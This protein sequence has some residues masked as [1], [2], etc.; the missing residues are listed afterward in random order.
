MNV[1]F[2]KYAIWFWVLKIKLFITHVCLVKIISHYEK[3]CCIILNA[4]V[5]CLF[6]NL[7]FIVFV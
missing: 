5:I 1:N 2:I 6:V 7:S 4:V 3:I